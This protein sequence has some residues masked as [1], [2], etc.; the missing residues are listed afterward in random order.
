MKYSY[1]CAFALFWPILNVI[2]QANLSLTNDVPIVDYGMRLAFC[3]SDIDMTD[4]QHIFDQHVLRADRDIEWMLHNTTSNTF[5]SVVFLGDTN[6]FDFHLF[7]TNG[8]EIPKTDKGKAMSV[9][10]VSITELQSNPNIYHE[11]AGLR[12][13]PR[14]PDLFQ[15]PSDGIY[16][17]EIR[18][19]GWSPS[20]KRFIL[21]S[22]VRLQVVKKRAI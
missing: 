11:G 12:D 8:V 13:F 4:P 15:F 16:I 10:P 21:S 3:N 22:P 5:L 2:A 20:A 6:S 9:G 17:L 18:Y 1:F 7:S 19:W 14:L